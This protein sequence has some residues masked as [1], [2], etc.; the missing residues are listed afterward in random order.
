MREL[1]PH[2]PEVMV[3]VPTYD[4]EEFSYKYKVGNASW[5]EVELDFSLT[6]S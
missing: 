2:E 6:F 3:V 4:I 5:A 1:M